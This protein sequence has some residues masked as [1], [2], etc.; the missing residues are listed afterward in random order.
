ME[1]LVEAI[2]DCEGVLLPGEAR[3]R[4]QAETEAAGGVQLDEQSTAALG[5]LAENLQ[6]ATPW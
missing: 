3:W 4:A 6:V 1:I 2:R 5:K